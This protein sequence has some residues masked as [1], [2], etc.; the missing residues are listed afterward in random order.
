VRLDLDVDEL[1]A[2]LFTLVFTDDAGR[3]WAGGAT[4]EQ[5]RA[6][7][8]NWSAVVDAVEADR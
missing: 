2:P 5:I 6:M 4:A 3:Q 7:V 8:A 1:G